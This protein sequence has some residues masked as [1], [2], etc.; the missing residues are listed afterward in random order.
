MKN[1][2]KL[3]TV[4]ALIAVGTVGFAQDEMIREERKVSGFSG[5]KA[6]GIASVYLKKGSQ[7]KVDVEVNDK[8][9]ND[10]L[11]VEVVDKVLVIRMD[12]KEKKDHRNQDVKLKIYVIYKHLNSLEGSGATNF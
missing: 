4:I 12:N 2:L 10:R 5:I 11:I 8:D 6:S 3:V 9:F 7:E 1:F